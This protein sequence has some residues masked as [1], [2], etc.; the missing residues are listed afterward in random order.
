MHN[1][2][3]GGHLQLR[4]KLDGMIPPECYAQRYGATDSE[5]IFLVAAGLGLDQAPIAAMEQA[6]GQVQTLAREAEYTPQMRFA[7]CW[8]DGKKVYAARY[9]SD[10]FVPSLF[11][12]VKDDG[13]V[14]GSEPLDDS[15]G[16][17]EVSPGT[18]IATDGQALQ[19]V[20]FRPGKFQ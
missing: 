16:W 14:I 11:Y 4:Q 7:A 20:E 12:Q 8:S 2:Q 9:A 15:A 18:A 6:V 10:R 13:V 1:G 3:L 5:A 19:K 17:I